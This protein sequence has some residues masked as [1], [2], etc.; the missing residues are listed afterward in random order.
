MSNQVLSPEQMQAAVDKLSPEEIHRNLNRAVLA[1][2]FAETDPSTKRRHRRGPRTYMQEVDPAMFALV[3]R[4][5]K[6]NPYRERAMA[7]QRIMLLY[8]AGASS[9]TVQQVIT[10]E[11]E[12]VANEISK[13]Y[14][15]AR[16]AAHEDFQQ[17]LPNLRRDAH[18]RLHT[19]LAKEYQEDKPGILNIRRLEKTLMDLVGTSQRD[20]EFAEERDSTGDAAQTL[21]TCTPRAFK[22]LQNQARQLKAKIVENARLRSAN[23]ELRRELAALIERLETAG[24]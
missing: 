6:G 23:R 3:Q 15:A 9:S 11:F 7:R 16:H 22:H 12:L 18:E 13:F 24:G 10:E 19:Q 21:A 20:V 5:E 1:H 17:D 2:E 8:L 14:V 4:L